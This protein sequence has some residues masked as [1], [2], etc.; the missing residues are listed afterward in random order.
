M[1]GESYTWDFFVMILEED[2][3]SP[4][5]SYF[6]PLYLKEK[7]DDDGDSNAQMN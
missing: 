4:L 6:S 3:F 2:G 5:N 1:K 7:E